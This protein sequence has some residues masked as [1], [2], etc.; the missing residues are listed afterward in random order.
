[1]ST[2]CASY[3]AGSRR[4]KR[5]EK[6]KETVVHFTLYLQTDPENT[7]SALHKY[8]ISAINKS[9]ASESEATA[10]PYYTW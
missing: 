6:C 7:D 4:S 3:V 5:E 9:F 10:W 2:A 1:M 8:M